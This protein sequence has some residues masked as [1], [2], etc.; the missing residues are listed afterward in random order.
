MFEPKAVIQRV[1]GLP[2]LPTVVARL[3]ELV[4][5]PSA[6]AGD[7]NDVLSRDMSLA[8]KI[9]KLVN[10]PF[11][12][13][14]RKISS[15]THA[16]VIL[17]FNTVRN[18]SLSAFVFEAFKDTKKGFKHRDFWIHSIGTAVA[19]NTVAVYKEVP[20]AEDAF[21]GGLLHDIGKVFLRQYCPREFDR[22]VRRVT[23]DDS[24][25]LDAEI[26]EM[27]MSHADLGAALLEEWSL[28]PRLVEIVKYHHRPDTAK[29]LPQLASAVHFGDILV[30]S[31]VIGSGGD[32][33][34]PRLAQPAWDALGLEDADIPVLMEK[35]LVG[36]EQVADFIELI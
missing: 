22:V 13:F 32:R 7:I 10:S 12:G 31:L 8:A 28:P 3:T 23:D 33:R 11:Y 21:M 27:D 25:F 6:S 9:L 26:A 17:G 36:I 29:T 4:E 1:D 14:S 19:A 16:V 24:L 18:V 20:E 34:I 5:D 35:T 2:T 30:R 15:V